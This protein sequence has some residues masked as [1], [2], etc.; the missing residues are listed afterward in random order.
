MQEV[1]LVTVQPL[2]EHCSNHLS[3]FSQTLLQREE[4]GQG[5]ST[6]M[7]VQTQAWKVAFQVEW[8]LFFLS[9]RKDVNLDSL[10][11]RKVLV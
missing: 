11:P 5:L 10:F 6:D 1:T 3:H 8:M 7:Q 2:P 4:A 9:T